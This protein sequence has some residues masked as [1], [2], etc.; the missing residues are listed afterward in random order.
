MMDSARTRYGIPDVE[1]Q[2]PGGGTV[3]PANFIGHEIVVLF[4][5]ADREE[6]ARDVA[7]YALHMKDL[8]DSDAWIIGI[9]DEVELPCEHASFTMARDRDRLA[10]DAFQGLQNSRKPT[11]REEGAVFLFDRGG[12]LRRSWAGSGHASDVARAVGQRR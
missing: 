2:K 7:Q 10:W 9:C 8:C 1:L 5:P 6:A 4:C 12:G 3:N 11:P